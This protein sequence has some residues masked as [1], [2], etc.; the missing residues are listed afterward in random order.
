MGYVLWLPAIILTKKVYQMHETLEKVKKKYW[1]RVRGTHIDVTTLER[2]ACIFSKVEDLWCVLQGF[3]AV[4]DLLFRWFWRFFGKKKCVQNIIHVKKCKKSD[5]LAWEVYTSM[6][7][8]CSEMIT[9]F[10]KLQ[11]S[12]AFWMVLRHLKPAEKV[13]QI[14]DTREN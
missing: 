11:M 13:C 12:L 2:K 7:P 6:S 4:V 14:V 10:E 3:M 5:D 8:R 1:F 9:F